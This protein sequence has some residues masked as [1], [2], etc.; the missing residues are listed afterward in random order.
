MPCAITIASHANKFFRL[1]ELLVYY[2]NGTALT[3]GSLQWP[4]RTFGFGE[5]LGRSEHC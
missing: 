1:N 3:L 5:S 4:Y 2:A